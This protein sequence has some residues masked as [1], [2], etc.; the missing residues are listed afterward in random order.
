MPI[1][2]IP[3]GGGPMP[4]MD[5]PHH[6]ALINFLKNVPAEFAQPKAIVI[7]SAHWEEDVATVTSSQEPGLLYDY[8]GFPEQYYQLNYPIKGNPE[9]SHR[10]VELIKNA[11]IKVNKDSKRNFDHGCFVP[12]KLMYPDAD[13][14]VVQISLINNLDAQAHLELGKAIGELSQE[15]VLI[16]GSGLSFHNMRAFMNDDQPVIKQAG[17]FNQWLNDVIVSQPIHASEQ[18]MS[19]WQ[20]AP[21]ARFCHPREE[22]LLPLHVCLGAAMTAN[23]TASNVFNDKILGIPTSGFLWQ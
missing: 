5:D 4:L 7:I 3:H 8:H 2:L 17:E 21:S 23:L 1:M 14:P 19:Q 20:E 18:S 12:L 9:L 6:Q 22:H 11:G 16:V 13:I 10:V 15:G